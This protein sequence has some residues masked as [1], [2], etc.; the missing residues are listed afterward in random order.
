MAKRRNFTAKFK[1]QVVLSILTGEK[2]PGEICREHSLH[3]NVVT[4]WKSEFIESAAS[5]FEQDGDLTEQENRIAELE[6]MIGRLTM[7]NEVL[8]KA[9]NLLNSEMK[10]SG[11]SS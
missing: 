5:I 7:E 6:R 9:S 8:K 10:K 1:A 3:H 4:R 11:R 2:T